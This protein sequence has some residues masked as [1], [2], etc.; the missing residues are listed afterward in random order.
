MN[1]APCP[2]YLTEMDRSNLNRSYQEWPR[3]FCKD[4]FWLIG[5][6]KSKR[7]KTLDSEEEEVMERA[8]DTHFILGTLG[9]LISSSSSR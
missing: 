5:N 9:S 1:L 3:L 2:T 8:N 7:V 4:S 6:A